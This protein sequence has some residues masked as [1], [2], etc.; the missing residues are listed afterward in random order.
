MEDDMFEIKEEIM[1]SKGFPLP[2]PNENTIAEDFVERNLNL[3]ID[4]VI[5]IDGEGSKD[6]QVESEKDLIGME[7]EI[8]DSKQDL[9]RKIAIKRREVEALRQSTRKN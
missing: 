9:I 5:Y 7:E 3:F 1:D 6:F 8:L 4:K 2:F